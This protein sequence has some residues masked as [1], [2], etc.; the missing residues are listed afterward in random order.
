MSLALETGGPSALRGLVKALG[1][2]ERSLLFPLGVVVVLFLVFSLST[3]S[4]ATIRNFTAISGQ[5][6]TLLSSGSAPPSSF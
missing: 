3:S 5:A 6:A 1:R 4:F 2:L